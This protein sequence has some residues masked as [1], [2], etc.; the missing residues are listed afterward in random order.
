MKKTAIQNVR[1]VYVDDKVTP[2]DTGD[3]PP[4]VVPSGV[5]IT[6]KIAK[7]TKLLLSSKDPERIQAALSWILPCLEQKNNSL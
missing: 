5:I 7:H 2:H 6:P 3:K 1:T 4:D